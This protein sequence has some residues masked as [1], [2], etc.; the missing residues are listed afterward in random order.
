MTVHA[1]PNDEQDPRSAAILGAAVEVFAR[2]GFKRTSMEDIARAAGM[3]RAALYLHYRNKQDIFRSLVRGYFDLA[4]ARLQA[5]LKPGLAPALALEAAFSAKLGPEMASLIDS[6]HGEEL[7][8][9]N[10]VT[11]ADLVAAGEARLGGLIA[12]WLQA[13]AAAGRLTLAAFDDDA[14]ALA[15]AMVAALGGLKHQCRSYEAL[16]LGMGRLARLFGRGL[17]P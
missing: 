3:S 10:C 4:E 7:M 9:A 6:P 5:A 17:I 16:R 12:A 15:Q 8:D 14:A 1:L 13:E 11:A 2:Y